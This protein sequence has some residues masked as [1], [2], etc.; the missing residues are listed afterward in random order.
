M[1]WWLCTLLSLPVFPVTAWTAAG[2]NVLLPQP[3]QV[4]YGP[5]RLRVRGLGIRL[6]GDPS[7]EDRFAAA[8]LSTCLSDV[9][10]EPVR[11]SE[12]EAAGTLIVL[13]RT[14][15]VGA[16][17][18]PGEHPGPASREAYS[19][20]LTPD[21][22]EVEATSSAGLFYGV[23]TLCQLIEGNAAEA[24]LP[25]VEIHDWPSLAYR[26]TMVDMSHGPLPTEAEIKRQLDFL[27]RWK[28]NQY[29]LYSE[30]SIELD[31]YPLLNPEGRLSKDE[32]RRII[33]Y[34]QERHI[35]VIPNLELYAHLHDLFRVEKYSELSDLPHGVEFNP[36]NPAVMALLRDWINQIADLFPSPFVSIGFD[37]TF[38]IEMA[39]KQQGSSASAT[40]LFVKQLIDVTRL[41]QQRGK[42]VMAWADIMVRY[43][44]IVADLPPG[45]IAVAWYYSADPDDRE[46]KHWLGPLVAK[47]VPH[48][49][50][51]G[52]TSWNQIAP[53]FDTSF[54]NIDTFIAAGRKSNALG[55]IN[56]LWT[57]DGQVLLRMSLPGMAYGAAAAWQS[58]P[59]DR[60]HFFSD[61][62]R[63]VYPANI[64]PDVATALEKLSQAEAELQK[65]LGE[66]TQV[67]LWE[68]PFF[69]TYLKAL[70]PNQGHLRRTRLLVEEAETH[71]YH[72]LASGADPTTLNSLLVGARLLDYAGQKFQ[73]PRELIELWGRIGTTRPDAD[74]WWNEWESQVVYQDHS[75]IVDLMDAITELR[76]LY[77]AEW[78]EEYSPYR[79][80][81]A[82][83]RWDA[84]YEYWRRLQQ[85]LQQ[86]S[87]G[88][89]QGDVL[90]PLEK[91]A[92]EH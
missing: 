23:Q 85:R 47:A 31:G 34:G 11:V 83:G 86:F 81:S 71:L 3:Q 50:Q 46:Y 2:H 89:H 54:E 88:S 20:K 59:I 69:P 74:K 79:L 80:A 25:E 7:V 17:P 38:Q 35:D 72:A 24:V 19:L 84:E 75:R 6:I 61:Y 63:I 39:V 77:Q 91:L 62:A 78:L 76:P 53:D 29:Y 37:E 68:D 41:F 55:V 28:A 43:P 5:G 82:L 70:T 1:R 42:Q 87:D 52:V 66:P 10:E 44:D 92:Q 13:K 90:P 18:L 12:G 27:T 51:P 64:S 33:A 21:G 57:D 26:G 40:R 65:V 67:N 4:H 30:A 36:S 48:F 16:L 73:T 49:V 60:P 32:V 45:L 56:S 9:A 58:T 15:D 8:Q 14:G 22:G